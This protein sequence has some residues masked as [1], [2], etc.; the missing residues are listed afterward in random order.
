MI[1]IPSVGPCLDE[2]RQR[3]LAGEQWVPRPTQLSLMRPVGVHSFIKNITSPTRFRTFLELTISQCTE[4]TIILPSRVS[5]LV[6][7]QN[8]TLDVKSR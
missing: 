2:A 8:V 6:G 7:S 5:I 3:V 4:Q 1:E